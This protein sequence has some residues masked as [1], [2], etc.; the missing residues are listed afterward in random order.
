[1]AVEGWKCCK[2]QWTSIS[3]RKIT[4]KRTSIVYLPLIS[5]STSQLNPKSVFDSSLA[6]NVAKRNIKCNA[7]YVNRLQWDVIRASVS[8]LRFMPCFPPL[9]RP[10]FEQTGA[11]RRCYQGLRIHELP[12]T[13]HTFLLTFACTWVKWKGKCNKFPLVRCSLP[14]YV[15]SGFTSI[16][17][18]ANLSSIFSSERSTL[19][20]I[21]LRT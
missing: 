6:V 20:L 19:F 14:F 13:W 5:K 9:S 7:Q 15:G 17:L 8:R 11:K 18:P 2:N 10:S 4:R 3:I 12:F 16:S 1:M 21:K